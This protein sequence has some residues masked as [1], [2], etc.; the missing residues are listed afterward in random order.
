MR[1]GAANDCGYVCLDDFHGVVAALSLGIAAEVSWDAEMADRGLVIYQYDHT[2]EGP[3]HPHAN[4]R[5]HR[6]QIGA[7]AS[8][9]SES[10]AVR[11]C[12]API[13]AAAL[14]DPENR[15]RRR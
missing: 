10:I 2:V 3:P 15:H 9:D 12:P 7:S 13:D 4:F 6:R 11:S 1:L 5:F 8:Q 14:G